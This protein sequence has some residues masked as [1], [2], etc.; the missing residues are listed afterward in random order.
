MIEG[1][2]H[3]TFVVRD[4]ELATRFFVEFLGG[5]EVYASGS[6]TFSLAPEKFFAAGGLWIAA[7]RGEPRAGRSYDHV[8]FAVREEDLDGFEERARAMGLDILPPRPRVPGEGCSL[9]VHDYDGH[10]FE[11]HAGSLN[12]RLARYAAGQPAVCA[13]EAGA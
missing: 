13:Q 1:L 6:D 11:L 3:L 10:L 4:L 5:R 8:A 2:S 7:M 12:E 9:Y